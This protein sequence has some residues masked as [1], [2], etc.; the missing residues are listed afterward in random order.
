MVRISQ[1]RT[2]RRALRHR[3]PAL[4]AVIVAASY[5]GTWELHK[6]AIRSPTTTVGLS[7]LFDACR[8]EE[9]I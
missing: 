4:V 8:E 2:L 1:C 5:V 9:A 6:V 3:A 7:V